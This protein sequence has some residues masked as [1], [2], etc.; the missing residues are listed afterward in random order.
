MTETPWVRPLPLLLAAAF[1]VPAVL[2]PLAPPDV[3]PWGFAAFGAIGLFAAGR[4]GKVG[5]PVAL[6]LTLGGKLAFDLLNYA[7]AVQRYDPKFDTLYWPFNDLPMQA[8]LYSSFAM[9]P[10]LGWLAQRKTTDPVAV[11]GATLLASV[12]FFLVT[13]FG[14]WL[15]QDLPYPL[16]PAGLLDCYAKGLPF[17]RGTLMSDVTFTAVLFGLNGALAPKSA[18]APDAATVVV[19][20]TEDVR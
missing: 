18:T 11:A 7:V 3:R 20:V 9:Y 16:T 14:S 6:A 12:Q 19:T 17:W 2:V 13:N 15:A 4:I 8:V 10:L 1:L 5:L